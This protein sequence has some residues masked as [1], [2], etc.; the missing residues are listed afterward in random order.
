MSVI[1]VPVAEHTY[2]IKQDGYL[3]GFHTEKFYLLYK[4]IQIQFR[5]KM[6]I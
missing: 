4:Q 3:Y 2:Y 6:E 5:R 1:V